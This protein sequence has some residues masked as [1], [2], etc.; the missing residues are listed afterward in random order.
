MKKRRMISVFVAIGILTGCTSVDAQKNLPESE[1]ENQPETDRVQEM[2][3]YLKAAG[4]S[5]IT[6]LIQMPVIF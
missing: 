4:T 3:A 5:E 1:T 2:N 6:F